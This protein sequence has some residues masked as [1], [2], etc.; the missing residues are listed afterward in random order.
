VGLGL[1][2]VAAI[3]G[4]VL[5]FRG[6][7]GRRAGA[8]GGDGGR[9]SG[10]A[11]LAPPPMPEQIAGPAPVRVLSVRL[12]QGSESLSQP[13]SGSLRVWSVRLVMENTG[14]APLALGDTCAVFEC[15]GDGTGY[16]GAVQSRGGKLFDLAERFAV[17][18]AQVNDDDNDAQSSLMGT[19]ITMRSGGRPASRSFGFLQPGERFV[20]SLDFKLGVLLRDEFLRSAKFVSPVVYGSDGKQGPAGILVFD[21]A[22]QGAEEGDRKGIAQEQVAADFETLSKLATRSE[23]ATALR[24]VAVNLL[25]EIHGKKAIEVLRTRLHAAGEPRGEVRAATIRA[26]GMLQDAGSA[27]GLCQVLADR[28]EPVGQRR[29]AASALG[30]LR[31]ARAVETLAR[32][33]RDNEQ[34][35]ATS[36]ISALGEIGSPAALQDLS[37]LLAEDDS[38]RA[39]N[40]TRALGGSGSAAVPLLARTL[41]G[42]RPDLAKAAAN[43]LERLLSR[44]DES[45][46]DDFDF[47]AGGLAESA[48]RLRDGSPALKGPQAD[49]AL[50]ALEEALQDSRQDVAAAAASALG[51]VP[52]TAAS[53]I[54]IQALDS[55]RGPAKELLQAV[56]GRRDPEAG[57]CIVR[58]LGPGES[59][60]VRTAAIHAA[61]AM[62][63]HEAEPGLMALAAS[64]EEST[65]SSAL[66]ALGRL[67]AARARSL[68]EKILA[69]RSEPE[70]VRHSALS[71]L[72]ELPQGAGE[73]TLLKVGG[74]PS[75]PVRWDCLEELRGANSPGAQ[76]AIRAALAGTDEAN[77]W[78]RQSLAQPPLRRRGRSAASDPSEGLASTSAEDR[79]DAADEIA[80]AKDRRMLPALKRAIGAEQEAMPLWRYGSALRALECR[81]LDL[82]PA[83][84]PRLRS[85]DPAVVSAAASLLRYLTGLHNGPYGRDSEAERAE[86]IA[87]WQAWWARHR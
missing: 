36:A 58:R 37:K 54:L 44:K 35:L 69:S 63:L 18:N 15:T 40:A 61:E 21:F 14:S 1:L 27:D 8:W 17:G 77:K 56:S 74:D 12:R 60:D 22:A 2:A 6:P 78:R 33:A 75:D 39:E 64:G 45:A 53:K 79:A 3:V 48:K 86:D 65:R 7:A 67:K 66:Y 26:L 20:L 52:G 4:L 38:R 28:K 80:K 68:L 87:A 83:L 50:R 73:A 82:V 49:A 72:R 5:F 43:A 11:P 9:A 46:E 23:S 29:L 62:E 32:L 85:T 70:T 47:G 42:D 13:W 84:L 55:G 16:Q 51:R 19:M 59:P 31:S 57:R 76:A 30:G 41:A 24:V 71:A 34:D 25:R 10:S 81:D